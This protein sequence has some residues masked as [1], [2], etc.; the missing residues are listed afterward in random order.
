MDFILFF[1]DPREWTEVQVAHWLDWAV[2]EFSLEGVHMQQFYMRGRDILAM[3]R[4]AFLTRAPP[5]MGDILWEH[6][7]IL[8]KGESI[9]TSFTHGLKSSTLIKFFV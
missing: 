1:L 7:E 9:R 3:G 8:Q 6:L 4:D 2:R 5:F